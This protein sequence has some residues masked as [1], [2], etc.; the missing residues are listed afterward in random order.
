MCAAIPLRNNSSVISIFKENIVNSLDD[1]PVFEVPVDAQPLETRIKRDKGKGK[2]LQ[3]P[4]KYPD[5]KSEAAKSNNEEAT[6]DTNQAEPEEIKEKT[7]T[8]NLKGKLQT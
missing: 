6:P 2:E 3:P 1:N 4:S 8:T 5:D 7:T